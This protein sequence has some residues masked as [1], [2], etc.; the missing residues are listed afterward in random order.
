MFA[1][2]PAGAVGLVI[3]VRRTRIRDAIVRVART[4]STPP[5]L[6]WVELGIIGR[7]TRIGGL[8]MRVARPMFGRLVRWGWSSSCAVLA[9]GAGLC[10]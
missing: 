2:P 9:S 5:T 8:H 1:D 3:I 4:M 10:G 7:C 6:G